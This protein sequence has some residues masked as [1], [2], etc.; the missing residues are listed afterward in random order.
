MYIVCIHAV[1]TKLSLFSLSVSLS[2]SLSLSL[3]VSLPVSRFYHLKSLQGFSWSVSSPNPFPMGHAFV[4]Y[5]IDYCNSLLIDIPKSRMSPLKLVLNAAARLIAR[6]TRFSHISTFMTEN[7]QRLQSIARIRCKIISFFISF[8]G[9]TSHHLCNLF[10]RPLS[11]TSYRPLR[12][13]DRHGLLLHRLVLLSAQY[14]TSIGS[15]L[16]IWF[17]PIFPQRL[18]WSLIKNVPPN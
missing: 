16:V 18:V 13:L 8:S 12:S 9:Q 17:G 4:C 3:C 14:R 7:L 11:A 5:R 10:R 15:V 2:A 1:C 6:L